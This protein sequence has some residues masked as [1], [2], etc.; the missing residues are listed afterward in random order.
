M[1]ADTQTK[2]LTPAHAQS[3]EEPEGSQNKRMGANL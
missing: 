3:T 1:E 2:P